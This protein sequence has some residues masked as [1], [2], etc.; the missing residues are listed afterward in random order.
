[1][2]MPNEPR[3]SGN[4]PGPMQKKKPELAPTPRFSPRGMLIWFAIFALML[5]AYQYYLHDQET[6]QELKFN[7]E[8]VQLIEQKKVTEC[9][10]VEENSGNQLK[11]PGRT[12]SACTASIIPSAQGVFCQLLITASA[13]PQPMQKA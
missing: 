6:V 3:D 13:V 12:S 9:E 2:D 11:S 10:V 1:M 7:P 4:L 5:M 8:F